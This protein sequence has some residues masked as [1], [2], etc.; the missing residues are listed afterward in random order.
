MSP[1]AT[2]V[3]GTPSTRSC[4]AT[5][6]STCCPDRPTPTRR[7]HFAAEARALAGLNHR[8]VVATY[9]TGVDGDGSSYRVDELAAGKPLD[10]GAVDDKFRVSFAT[11]IARAIADAHGRGL[12]H[13][14][15]TSG[16][17]LVDDEGRVKVR[18]LQLPDPRRTRRAASGS[19][20]T[21]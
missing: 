12:V 6:S 13:G 11:Q 20:S 8:N 7:P 17:V 18:G 5:S 15:L 19:T 9:D 16:S 3:A 2:T 21:R 1:N 14:A 10:P 4:G